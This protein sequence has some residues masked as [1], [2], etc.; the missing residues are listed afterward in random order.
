MRFRLLG[1]GLQGEFSLFE[2][3]TC[4]IYLHPTFVLARRFSLKCTSSE[5]NHKPKL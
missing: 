5:V 1:G 3:E 4:E 2:I